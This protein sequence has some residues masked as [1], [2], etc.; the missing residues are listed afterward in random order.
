VAPPIKT[1][2]ANTKVSTA[3]PYQRPSHHEISFSDHHH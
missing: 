3:L 1:A 2:A